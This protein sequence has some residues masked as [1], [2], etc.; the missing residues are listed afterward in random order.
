MPKMKVSVL[1]VALRSPVLVGVYN[2]NKLIKNYETTD[3]TSDA[4]PSIF[5]DILEKYELTNLYYANGPGSYMSIKLTFIFLRTLSITH[6]V[7]LGASSAFNF[8]DNMPIKALGKKYFVLEGDEIVLET[9]TPVVTKFKIPDRLN[10]IEFSD[11]NEPN[12]ILPAV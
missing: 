8:C 9:I 2:D 3:M 6:N 11:E 10:E 12:Y 5:K 4:L 1:V 7:S